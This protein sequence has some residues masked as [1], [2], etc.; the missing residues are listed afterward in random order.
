MMYN[1]N[2]GARVRYIQMKG[3]DHMKKKRLQLRT[4]LFL[5][6]PIIIASVGLRVYSLLKDFDFASGYFVSRD[7][8]TAASAVAIG[9]VIFSLG[10]LLQS[11]LDQGLIPSFSNPMTYVTGSAASVALLF[12]AVSALTVQNTE[13]TLSVIIDALNTVLPFL[14]I[15][16]VGLFIT[17][18]LITERTSSLRAVFGMCLAS[19]LAI[20]AVS[21]FLFD[22]RLMNA[23]SRTVDVMAYIITATFFLFEVRLSLG[24]DVWRAYAAV[25]MATIAVT[26]YS[27]IPTLTVYFINGNMISSSIYESAVTLALCLYVASRICVTLTLPEDKKS[28]LVRMINIKEEKIET[29]PEASNEQAKTEDNA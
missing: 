19:F 17:N 16:S 23:E 12:F 18:M 9:A 25:G 14:A 2:Y 13:P 29:D 24:R 7:I 8:I 26:A 6:L 4:Y 5:L 11:E 10:Y 1:I 15:G 21:L 22:A 28:E 3:F 20:H 27:A